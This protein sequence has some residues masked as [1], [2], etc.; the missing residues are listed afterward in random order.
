VARINLLTENRQEEEKLQDQILERSL[1][2]M[3]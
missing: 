3:Q 1:E 2:A